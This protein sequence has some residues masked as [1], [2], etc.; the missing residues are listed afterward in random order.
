MDFPPNKMNYLKKKK[1][2]KMFFF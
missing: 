2:G 1:R